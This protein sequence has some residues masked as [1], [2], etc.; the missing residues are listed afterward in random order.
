M[1][2][3]RDLFLIFYGGLEV[4]VMCFEAFLIFI[5]VGKFV[6]FIQKMFKIHKLYDY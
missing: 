3:S 1:N 4:G 6:K 5:I 2:F